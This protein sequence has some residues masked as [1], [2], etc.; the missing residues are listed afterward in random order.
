MPGIIA[1]FTDDGGMVDLPTRYVV[2]AVPGTV[3]GEEV[4]DGALIKRIELREQGSA[5]GKRLPGG[6][7]VINYHEST[8]ETYIPVHSVINIVYETKA[9]NEVKTPELED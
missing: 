3:G 9:A 8:I 4:E 2:G 5:F 1:L 6:V 7:F